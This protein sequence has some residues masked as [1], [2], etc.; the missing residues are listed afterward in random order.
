MKMSQQFYRLCCFA[1]FVSI[2]WMSQLASAAQDVALPEAQPFCANVLRL[3]E[4][5][6][7]LGQQ[8]PPDD[9]TR[10]RMSLKQLDVAAVQKILEPHVGVNL[11]VS[12]GVVEC[13][14]RQGPLRVQQYGL[15][16]VIC[17]IQNETG[18]RFRVRLRS[19]QAGPIY[20]G[21][22]LPILARQAQ[23]E[24]LDNENRDQ[25]ANRFLTCEWYKDAPMREE[26]SGLVEEWG[27]V[28]LGTSTAGKR[29]AQIEFVLS[30]PQAKQ[31]WIG[32]V[33]LQ[34]ESAEAIPVQLEIFDE[35]G[36]PSVG[37]LTIRD[38]LGRV[39][40]PQA[41]RVAPDFFFQPQIYRAHG[42]YVILP[43]GDYQVEYS[44]GPEYRVKRKA[45]NVKSEGENRWRFELERWID[46]SKFG[47]YVGD[48][49][50]HGAGCSHYEFPTQGVTPQDMFYQV[51][52]EGLNV[53]CVLTWGPCFEHQRKY[54]SSGVNALNEPMTIL[55][56]D[57]EISG[58]GSHNLGH[59]CLLDL[60]DQN[61][62]GS[63]GTKEYGWPTWTVPVMRW[64]KAQG[65]VTGYPHSAV[66]VDPKGAASHLLASGDRDGDQALAVDEAKSLLLPYSFEQCDRSK[67]G[68][69][70]FA[71]LEQA[72]NRAADELPNYALPAMNGAGGMEIFVSAVE[73]V[74]DF[75][76]A[77]DTPR[78][79]EW[80]T[81]Y[82]LMN[83]GL[84]IKLSGETD[85]PCM[86]SRR[87]GQGRVYVQLGEKSELSFTEWCRGLA[88]GRSYVSDG[89][90]HALKFEVGGKAPGRDPLQLAGARKVP[91]SFTVAFAE[92]TPLGVAYGTLEVDAGRRIS[93]DTVNLHAPRSEK[94]KSGGVRTVELVVNGAV[95][96][97]WDIPAD[98]KPHS[99]TTETEIDKS[100]W[101]AIRQFPQLHTNPV[102][103]LVENKPIRASKKSGEW[104]LEAVTLLRG[105]RFRFISKDEV[106]EAEKG[107]D[108]AREY[109][110]GVVNSANGP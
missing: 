6:E 15:I 24:L 83:C 55:K 82:H 71:E 74:C 87:V 32:M 106:S 103:V 108:R 58:F 101:V 85:F 25:N 109:Y 102:D 78:V 42:Q 110:L 90:A 20:A 34:L 86:S 36:E 95:V 100:S 2:G 64:A 12:E 9:V 46:P 56:Y 54:F 62:P 49:H 48:H 107:Y 29:E 10:L 7:Y 81:W 8:L 84:A 80:N 73:G 28:L 43:P 98:G 88:D 17:R 76:S 60:K 61:Y 5:L 96:E 22:S 4:T 37:S 66:G 30:E 35:N 91:V 104:C 45:L 94:I 51:K 44:R 3:L 18:K 89:Y 99:I 75:T 33:R 31:E 65:G 79:S 97:A 72:S 105:N 21:A 68:K 1:V 23:T 63:D 50:I 16:P 40:P 11:S 70:E 77:M 47:F 57:L 26:L 13:T 59:V 67:N 38:A 39:Y 92:E 27:I 93:G 19:E 52:G 53:G 41:K 14:S 69:L